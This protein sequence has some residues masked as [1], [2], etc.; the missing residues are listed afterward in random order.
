MQGAKVSHRLRVRVQDSATGS[1]FQIIQLQLQAKCSNCIGQSH[2]GPVANSS[3]CWY[4]QRQGESLLQPLAS[5]CRIAMQLVMLSQVMPRPQCTEVVG[6]SETWVHT[7]FVH[8]RE[9]SAGSGVLAASPCKDLCQGHRA[10]A[11]LSTPKRLF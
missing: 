8:V 11:A 4:I 6:M 7:C 1:G 5:V 3:C 9:V 10:C 2:A